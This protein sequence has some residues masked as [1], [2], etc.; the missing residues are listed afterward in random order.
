MAPPLF[1]VPPD[2]FVKAR[3]A[4]V[5][6]LRERGETEEAKRIASLR[7]PSAALWVTNQLGPRAAKDVEALIESSGRARNAQLHGGGDALREAI[8]AQREAMRRLMAEA[9]MPAA[10]I[11]AALTPEMQR[12]I[13]NTLQTA[14][15]AAPDALRE[16]AIE[17]EMSA[18]G[19]GALLSGPAAV[20]LK[21]QARRAAFED[22]KE[23]Q[24]RL[25]AD[26]R[27]RLM[28]Q[29][30]A[31]RAQ[32]DARRLAVRAEQL[33]KIAHKAQ[34]AADKAKEKAKEARR[35]AD[36][37]AARLMEMRDR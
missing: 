27:E 37:R 2:E 11:G 32:L 7:R 24:K 15:T 18:A 13:Q 12:R 33:E 35:A 8:Q 5:R 14:A 31:Q 10:E 20:A 25:L 28:R 29:R 36:E 30:Q 19:F 9:Q 17:H 26:K 34:I 6:Q 22:H 4:L 16:G 21:T 1:Q 3:D 23:Q